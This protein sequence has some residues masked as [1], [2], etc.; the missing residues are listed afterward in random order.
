[1]LIPEQCGILTHCN[2]GGLATAGVGTALGIIRRAHEVGKKI[3]VFVDET[4][5]LLQGGRLTTWELS[6][7][8]VPY[9]LIADNM[10]AAVMAQGKVNCVVVGADRITLNGDVVNKVGTY[11]L[12]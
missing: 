2:T 12:A 1:Q 6:K 3:H 4:R 7:L 9:T 10:A 8:K 11:G 5:P